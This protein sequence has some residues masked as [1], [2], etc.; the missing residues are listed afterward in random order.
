MAKLP[1]LPASPDSLR[2][3]WE[4]LGISFTANE[5]GV[6]NADPERT[7]LASLREFQ[8]DRKLLKL[9]LAWLTS[10]GD[11]VHV[12]RIKALA[13]DLSAGELAWLGGLAM[14]QVESSADRRWQTVVDFVKKRL[15]TPMPQFQTSK[16]DELQTQR[17]GVDEHFRCFGLMLP[18]LEVADMKK[19]RLRGDT[20]KGSMWF[21]MRALFGT[22][23]RA[24]V[25]VTM[26]LD[27]A[28][29][30]YQAGRVL[31]CST[32]TAYRNWNSLL[33]AGLPTL[34]KDVA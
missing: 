18:L 27:S 33:E 10:F 6:V 26:L 21:R 11:L 31:G 12:E 22:N 2:D 16:L 8:D 25:A 15:G 14:H 30:S 3:A 23:W 1:P 34:F 5:S 9:V 13:G 32:E 4:N 28:K 29:T 17:V 19:I 20:L 7:L 24:D